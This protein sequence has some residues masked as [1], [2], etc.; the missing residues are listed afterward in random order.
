[1]SCALP[2]LG[3]SDHNLVYLS[4]KYIP[5]VH[6]RPATT[7]SVRV[8]SDEACEQLKGC[9]D[10]TDWSIFYDDNDVDI[11]TDHVT[12]YINF[13][14]NSVIPCKVIRC[15]SNNKPWVTKEVKAALNRKKVAFGSKDTIKI[16]AAQ[17]DLK[18]VIRQGKREYRRTVSWWKRYRIRTAKLNGIV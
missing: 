13:C 17:K 2:P 7:K 16:K 9:F 11:I 5:I 15:F 14:V 10:C 4:P 1:M 8:W 6:R 18:K 12:S 3:Q